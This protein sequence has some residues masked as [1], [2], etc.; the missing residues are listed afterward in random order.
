[1]YLQ[2]RRRRRQYSYKYAELSQYTHISN[3]YLYCRNFILFS[4]YL[5]NYK[6]I[7]E[8][9]EMFIEYHENII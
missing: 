5:N 1:M 2:S 7:Y 9:R 6:Q 4:L 3:F 8:V